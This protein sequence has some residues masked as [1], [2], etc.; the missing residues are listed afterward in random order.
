MRTLLIFV[1][2]F[3]SFLFSQNVESI[4]STQKINEL[5]QK[6]DH[7]KYDN[8]TNCKKYIDSAD[9]LSSN[10]QNEADRANFYKQTASIYYDLDLFNLSLDYNLKAYDFYKNQNSE[11][12]DK[13]ENLLAI[14][15]A[16]LNNK[17][18]AIKLFRKIYKKSQKSKNNELAAISLNNIGN[19]YYH[20][21]KIDSALYFYQESIRHLGKIDNLQLAIVTN[22]NIAK[23]YS[24][25]N[26]QHLALE[27]FTKAEK[28][29]IKTQDPSIRSNFYQTLTEYYLEQKNAEKAIINAEKANEFTKVKYSFQNLA[30]LKNLYQ[31][32]LLSGNYKK[33]AEYFSQYDLVR[34]SLNIEEKA[35]NVEKVKIEADYKTK[36]QTLLLE[37]KEKRL[38]LL[39]TI[40]VLLILTFILIYFLIRYK[41][42]LDKQKLN[43]QLSNLRE[44]ELKLDLEL[45]NKELVS[46]TILEAERKEMY[47]SI[48]DDLKTI[49]NST[50]LNES[51]QE[52]NQI[53]KKLDRNS[54]SAAWEEFNL[55]FTNIYES[56][57]EK[58]QK[59]HPELNQNEKRLCSLIK[60]NLSSKEIAE[61]TNTTVKSV[62]NSRTRL[63]KKLGLTNTKTELHQYLNK[64]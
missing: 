48:I 34:D 26:Q 12:A 49:V 63:R 18:D 43:N 41:N 27:Y 11:E 39:S 17:K 50:T 6:A 22:T 23:I 55:R 28:F 57:F 4:S 32:Y 47:E 64:I 45:R 13:I 60:L 33:S 24:K 1:L 2:F 31:S 10:S 62:E 3:N 25:K 30:N 58:L 56:F 8:W 52:I 16:R 29:L 46:K 7:L 5:L 21:G 20:W 54:S 19:T 42:N 40:I 36:E 38:R 61:I 9:Y 35:V 51:K 59:I 37:N 44:N 53:I 14:I 15:N